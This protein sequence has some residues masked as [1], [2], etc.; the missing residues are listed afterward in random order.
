MA[1]IKAGATKEQ[2]RLMLQSLLRQRFKLAIHLVKVEVGVYE[3]AIAKDGPKFKE[4]E[5]LSVSGQSAA[6]SQI[7]NTPAGDIPINKDGC[8]VLS[9][10]GP[11]TM[12][13]GDCIVHRVMNQPIDWLIGLLSVSMDRPITDGTGLKGK[14]DFIFSY[15]LE[16]RSQTAAPPPADGISS[17]SEPDLSKGPTLL[18]A[19]RE[20][21]GLRLDARKSLLEGVVVDHM[22][23]VPTE[24]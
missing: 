17:A 4:S 6:S 15:R 24:N 18:V 14:Y 11:T 2:F 20:Q 7:R 5:I 21:L 9:A 23:K 13:Y 12:A 8:A 22:E 19:L 16:K 3:L 1:R 10:G